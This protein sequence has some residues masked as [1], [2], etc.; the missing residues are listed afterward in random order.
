MPGLVDQAAALAAVDCCWAGFWLMIAAM[1]LLLLKVLHLAAAASALS[2][3]LTVAMLPA[4]CPACWA[5]QALDQ[6]LVC[7]CSLQLLP[8]TLPK[9]P[10]TPQDEHTPCHT[11]AS[12]G[13]TH[14]LLCPGARCLLLLLPP[15][16]LLLL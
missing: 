16:L 3:L 12:A 8:G 10:R 6:A 15:L 13:H 9:R 4:A 1:G 11:L 2:A 7:P 14:S 5:L